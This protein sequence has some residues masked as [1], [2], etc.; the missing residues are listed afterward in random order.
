MDSVG[1]P[2]SATSYWL[3][4][5]AMPAAESTELTD[6]DVAVVGGGIAGITTAYLLKLA[7]SRVALVEADRLAR[8]VTGHTTAKVSAAHGVKYTTLERHHDREVAVE[9]G[10]SQLAALSWLRERVDAAGIEC[11]LTDQDS[12]VY[13]ADPKG[14][15][16]LRAEAAAAA[17]ARS[18]SGAGRRGNRRRDHARHGAGPA[19]LP[20][21]GHSYPFPH[22]GP[23]LLL[24]PD[25]ASARCR[26]GGIRPA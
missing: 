14:A 1:L 8:G 9:Y 25:G 15:D 21:R 16:A 6:V 26:G 20:R 24:R 17:S 11:E 18:A 4:S 3:A 13:T 7:G 22:S 10:A 23:W 12:Y 19:A 5:A 2:S